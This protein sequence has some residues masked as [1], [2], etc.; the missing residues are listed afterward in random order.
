M[1]WYSL[2]N[3]RD[4]GSKIRSILKE[5]EKNYLETTSSD[6]QGIIKVINK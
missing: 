3:I 2:L 1:T 6:Y 5:E 4:F